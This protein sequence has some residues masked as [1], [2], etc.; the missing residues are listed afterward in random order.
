[1]LFLAAIVL[2]VG[3]VVASQALTAVVIG[4]AR[5]YATLNALG[6]GKAALRWVV[7]EQAAWIGGLGLVLGSLLST[8]LLVVAYSRDVPVD[9]NLA[10]ALTCAVLVL[11]LAMT[12]GL[13]AMRGLMRADPSLL[14]R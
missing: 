9:M 6:A 11:A 8:A 4:S 7:L 5:E 14:L 3:A 12:S 2:V 10:T 1:V 13:F